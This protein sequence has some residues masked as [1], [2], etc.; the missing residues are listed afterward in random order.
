MGGNFIDTANA[1]QA[2]ESETCLGEWMVQSPGRRDE[3][4]IA[5]KYTAGFIPVT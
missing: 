5:T 4:V 3:M 2:E 1:Y